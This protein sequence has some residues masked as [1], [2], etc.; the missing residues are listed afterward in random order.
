ML[1]KNNLDETKKP[2][3]TK[4][5]EIIPA[6]KES[7]GI[8]QS[9]QIKALE[10]IWP[11]ITSFEVAKYSKP[12]HF[13]RENNLVISIKSSALAAELSMQ[14]ITILEKLK[15]AVKNTDIRFQNIRFINK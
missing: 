4:A 14:K 11:L 13:D 9:L 7:L 1:K 8:E 3:L 15:E 2:S 6:V 12:S 5:S 10:E